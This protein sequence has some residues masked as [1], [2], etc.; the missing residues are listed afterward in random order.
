MAQLGFNAEQSM[1]E[2]I[3]II[4]NKTKKELQTPEFMEDTN[5]HTVYKNKGEKTDLDSYRGLFILSILGDRKRAIDTPQQW[6]RPKHFI[7]SYMT[8][9][10]MS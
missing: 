6:H 1:K 5:I 2:S 10:K 3:L 9:R 7:F 8:R 4:L